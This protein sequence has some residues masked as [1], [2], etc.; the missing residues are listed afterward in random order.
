MSTAKPAEEREAPDDVLDPDKDGAD[1]EGKQPDAKELARENESLK[2]QL[3]DSLQVK[4][5]WEARAKETPEPKPKA[6]A[7]ADDDDPLESLDILKMITEAEDPKAAAKQLKSALRASIKREGYVSRDE[8]NAT[9]QAL[10]GDA[11]AIGLLSQEYP[12][13][14]N[15]K[16]DLFAE[17]QKQLDTLGKN[18]AYKNLPH[19]ELQRVAVERAELQLVRSGKRKPEKETEAERRSRVHEQQGRVGRSG[20]DT[21]SSELTPEQKAY[22]KRMGVSEDDLKKYGTVINATPNLTMVLAAQR[23]AR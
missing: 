18:A 17:T 3:A 20:R 1:V 14:A 19:S 22:A 10:I 9:L 13:L 7:K 15:P 4:E 5:F 12:D 21:G 2:R 16:S 8:L 23:E 6:E 11:T